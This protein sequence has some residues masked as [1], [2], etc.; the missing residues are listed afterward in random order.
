[1][2]QQADKR[3]AKRKKKAKF[4]KELTTAAMRKRKALGSYN[5]IQSRLLYKQVS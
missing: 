4:I 3:R 2:A 5:S 1:M